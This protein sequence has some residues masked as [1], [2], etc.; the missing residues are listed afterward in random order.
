MPFVVDN[1]VVTGWFF[2][3]QATPSPYTDAVLER[4]E[5]DTAHVPG[6]WVLEFSNVLRKA[7]VAKRITDARTRE[8]LTQLEGLSLV[9]DWSP[10]DIAGNM[11]L[12]LRY[13]LTSYDTA[14]LELALRLQHPIAVRD[15]ALKSAA[16]I[17]GVGVI[18]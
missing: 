1:S 13:G 8:I 11:D 6:L 9:I 2:E 14:Y 16:D 3:S 15:S 17:S 12:A 5:N 7:R 18:T 4:L 10:V